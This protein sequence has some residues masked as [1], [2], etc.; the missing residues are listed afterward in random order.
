MKPD[1]E[2]LVEKAKEKLLDMIHRPC[3]LDCDDCDAYENL[4]MNCRLVDPIVIYNEFL[5]D[6]DIFG[7]DIYSLKSKWTERKRQLEEQK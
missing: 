3:K 4:R 1:S 5:E 7:E 6:I 2:E